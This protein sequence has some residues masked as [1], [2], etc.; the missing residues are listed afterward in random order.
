[1]EARM[2]QRICQ[3]IAD[4]PTFQT[5]IIAVI[6]L[7]AILVGMET[8]HE[9]AEQNSVVFS[10]LDTVLL[11][12]F[13]AEVV[14]R[15]LAYGSRPWEFFRN[16]WNI[17]D[18]L[19]VAIFYL[20]F[21]GSEVAILRLAR[22]VRM[23]RLIKAVPGLRMLVMALFYSLPSMGYIGLLLLIHVYVYGIVGSF[24]FGATDPERFGHVG[25]SMQ[26]LAQV[27]T[28]DDWAA[29]MRA[30]ENRVVAAA[31]F[32]SF[33]LTGTMIILNLF[34]GV[35]MEGFASAKA[36]FEAERRVVVAAVQEERDEVEVEL[37]RIQEQLTAL[38]QDMS[39]LM[40]AIQR[41]RAN[42]GAPGTPRV[43]EPAEP[44][45]RS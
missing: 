10:T 23:M 2:V 3:R 8:F 6:G 27:V 9:F 42:G 36:Q 33:I 37:A 1:M 11:A 38:S 18:F 7:A 31:Y 34:I 39:R 15:V 14:I 26:T 17:F 45:N 44:V 20:P 13:T 25:D 5:F 30:Q 4:S 22:V 43:T 41:A 40:A 12:I 21:V 29:V 24:L 16:G 19:T 35:I 28:F 32:I